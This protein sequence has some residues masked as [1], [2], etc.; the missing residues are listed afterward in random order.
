MKLP[1]NLQQ[2]HIFID[3]TFLS[4]H[5][6]RYLFP[7]NILSL[8]SPQRLFF[9]CFSYQR[10]FFIDFSLQSFSY[11]CHNL[12]KFSYTLFIYP[13]VKYAVFF[14]CSSHAD[15]VTVSQFLS[16]ISVIASCITEYRNFSRSL[17]H[18]TLDSITSS[19]SAP[20]AAPDNTSIH[21]QNSPNIMDFATT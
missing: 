4:T 12:H 20:A 1:N 7:D 13:A 19:G 16:D 5:M 2:D 10:F 15:A 18:R 17:L 21:L 8:F 11:V 9:H 3:S 6:Y 14:K